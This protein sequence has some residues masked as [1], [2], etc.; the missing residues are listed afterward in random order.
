MNPVPDY[1][2][3]YVTLRTSARRR[4]LR[5][6]LHRRP[7]QRRA[8]RRHPGAGPAGRRPAGRRTCSPTSAAFSRAAD[9]RQPA[10]LARPGEGRH[11]HGRRRRC[12]NAVW[13]LYARAAPGKPL[14]QLLADLSPGAARRR[15]ST[16]AT[17][18]TRSPSDEALE[19]LRGAEPGRA[20][21]EA[22]LL[23]DGYPAYTTT[24]GWLGYDDEKLVRLSKAGRRRRLR[25]DQAE[26]RRRPRPTT[27]AGCGSPARRSAP[28]SASRSTPTRSGACARRSTGWSALAPY[29]P[30]WIEEPTSPDDVLGHAAI[31]RAVAPDQGGHRR[32]RATTR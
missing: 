22:Q 24:P 15:S 1:S 5:P 4:G 8:G 18:A 28:T 31:R 30:Y 11:P 14:W 25:P 12:V 2:A 10:A 26:G 20:E 16:S 19:L 23:A 21:R 6:R 29:D 7:R 9:R 27:S 3:A 17:C 32:A 13:D